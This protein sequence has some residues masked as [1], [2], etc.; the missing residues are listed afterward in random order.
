MRKV[1][2][3]YRAVKMLYLV[4][5]TGRSSAMNCQEVGC[6]F[7]ECKRGMEVWW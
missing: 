2:L 6:F 5:V 7:T 3:C 4:M 1:A